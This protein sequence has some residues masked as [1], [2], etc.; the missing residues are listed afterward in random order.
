MFLPAF[1]PINAVALF[2]LSATADDF[3]SSPA[4]MLVNHGVMSVPSG[5][6][7]NASF[8]SVMTHCFS[9]TGRPEYPF[10]VTSESA[11]SRFGGR[12]S[13]FA[14]AFGATATAVPR[15]SAEAGIIS[16][17]GALYGAPGV[18]LIFIFA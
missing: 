15:A 4:G 2:A 7:P 5:I 11:A 14:L 18:P 17:T 13:H 10:T 6:A 3:A 8:A 9:A 1:P 12:M 16:C